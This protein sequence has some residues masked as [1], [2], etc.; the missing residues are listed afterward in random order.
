MDLTG[1]YNHPIR[2]RIPNKLVY[3]GHIY[4]FSWPE[5]VVIMWK[6]GSYGS[7][8][9]RLFNEQTYVRNL[10]VPFLFGELGN[11]CQDEYWQYLMQYLK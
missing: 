5:W 8:W 7:F 10:N 11:N 4:G 6:V 2:L 9:E 1:V 3:T